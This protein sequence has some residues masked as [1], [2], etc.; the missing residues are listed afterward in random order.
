MESVTLVVVATILGPV[1]AVQAQKWIERVRETRERKL[2]IFYALM[3]S[4]AARTSPEHVQAL[5]LIDLLFRRKVEKAIIDAWEVYREHLS[6]D[7]EKMTPAQLEAWTTRGNDH[8]NDL[9]YAMSMALG[10]RFTRPQIQRGI[11]SPRAHS[12]ADIEQQ[13]IRHGAAMVL[14]GNQALKM[15]VTAFPVSDDAVNLQRD[16]QEAM[17]DTLTKQRVLK[18]HIV[19][20]DETEAGVRLPPPRKRN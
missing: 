9:M 13:A 6:Q 19:N 4:R 15:D 14:S 18:V 8:F 1:L 12:I 11:Y 17:L 3:G 5:N 20:E 10:Y 7:T 16:V 2:R